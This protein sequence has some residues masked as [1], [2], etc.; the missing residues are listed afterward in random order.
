VTLRIDFNAW[1]YEREEHLLIPLLKT[2]ERTL[3]DYI[4]LL[5]STPP[6]PS[7]EA[8]AA[9]ASASAGKESRRAQWSERLSW[10]ADRAT[11][12]GQ[13]AIAMTKM[14]KVK[15]GIPG[16]GEVEVAPYE[17]L[18]AAQAQIDRAEKMKEAQEAKEEAR[19]AAAA[20]KARPFDEQSLYYNIYLELRRLTRGDGPDAPHLNFVFLIDDL[21]R[22]LPEKAVETLESIKL[23]LDVEGCVFVLAIDD[24]VVE[25]GIAHR[26]RDYL[27]VTDRAAESID[28]SLNADL[29][30]DYLNRYANN[31]QPPI[32]GS[33]YLEKI[34]Q[35]PIR[36]PRFSRQ[37][38]T[39]LLRRHSPELF[40]QSEPMPGAPTTDWLLDLFLEAVPPVP[41]KLIRAADLLTFVRQLAQRQGVL[42]HLHAYTLA[43]LVL[44]QLFAPQMFRY[45]TRRDRMESWTRLDARMQAARSERGVDPT[46]ASFFGWWE[47]AMAADREV[48][49]AGTTAGVTQT[50]LDRYEEP[51]VAELRQAVNTRSGF[52][53]RR[54]FHPSLTVD[55]RLRPYFNLLAEDAAVTSPP[56]SPPTPPPGGTV[57]PGPSPSLPPPVSVKPPAVPTAAPIV[58]PI[59]TTAPPP[60]PGMAPVESA[61]STIAA[62]PRE[63]ENFIDLLMSPHA[64]SWH[65]ALNSEPG[66]QGR[67]LDAQSFQ[68]LRDRINQRGFTISG[69]WLDVVGV[70][71]SDTQIKMLLVAASPAEVGTLARLASSSSPFDTFV[72]GA[73][74][75]VVCRRLQPWH[76]PI[77]QDLRAEVGL[78]R[79]VDIRRPEWAYRYRRGLI[80]DAVTGGEKLALWRG[81][82]RVMGAQV[83]S[84][85]EITRGVVAT[86]SWTGDVRLW[87]RAFRGDWMT[88]A[89]L[90][91]RGA[92]NVAPL[93]P[94]RLVVWGPTTL[95]IWRKETFDRWRRTHEY[96]VSQPIDALTVL[97]E[98]CFVHRS[99]TGSISIWLWD[100]EQWNRT[101]KPVSGTLGI[102]A[103]GPRRFATFGAGSS[104]IYDIENGKTGNSRSWPGDQNP[105][106]AVGLAPG[107]AVLLGTSGDLQLVRVGDE[108]ITVLAQETS[109]IPFGK[110]AFP[111]NDRFL[112]V[113]DTGAFE[114]WV[115]SLNSD[116][117]GLKK[118]GQGS[119]GTPPPGSFF[120]PEHLCVLRDGRVLSATP[121]AV[122]TMA[123]NAAGRYEVES[124]MAEVNLA[125]PAVAAWDSGILLGHRQGAVSIELGSNFAARIEAQI[126]A[127]RTA[128]RDAC[129][130]GNEEIALVDGGSTV[131][132]FNRTVNSVRALSL[133]IS[134]VRL[135]T[136]AGGRL[137]V[138]GAS[139]IVELERDGTEWTNRRT[140]FGVPADYHGLA[141]AD[142]GELIVWNNKQLCAFGDRDTSPMSPPG[143]GEWIGSVGPMSKEKGTSEFLVCSGGIVQVLSL[144]PVQLSVLL[145]PPDIASLAAAFA[146][147][148]LLVFSQSGDLYVYEDITLIRQHHHVLHGVPARLYRLNDHCALVY[149]LD[150]AWY[151]ID[152]SPDGKLRVLRFLV[153]DNAVVVQ[154]IAVDPDTGP[155]VDVVGSSLLPID[156]TLR[157][158]NLGAEWLVKGP[159]DKMFPTDDAVRQ[160]LAFLR[161]SGELAEPASRPETMTLSS[162]T[163]PR[164]SP[165]LLVRSP[166]PTTALLE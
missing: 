82:H 1:R 79:D 160:F 3:D 35:L 103:L 63:L 19:K 97:G 142:T 69:R 62:A 2:I 42:T 80:S 39:E 74:L 109:A 64:D 141:A 118:L 105:K 150:D 4:T 159:G 7:P 144:K 163:D 146:G 60:V 43:Q 32:T 45:L 143:E 157:S 155:D 113:D 123:P 25:R 9:T 102:I 128:F 59:T 130:I 89:H 68:T 107:I 15:A 100:G 44:L 165:A 27:D 53:P 151:R 75:E 46:G 149:A 147:K 40:V 117:P 20:K 11:L 48:A 22:C 66:L 55:P 152:V 26:Y 120:R 162:E 129:S 126:P 134:D 136:S 10:L 101:E 78:P 65:G 95:W 137:Y 38:A 86:C 6:E 110:M 158:M 135:V 161:V 71:L 84:V 72:L 21:D 88:H 18:T 36:L 50:Q 73:L 81:Y 133:D 124:V 12:V 76:A 58:P 85:R 132:L 49:K 96:P 83:S 127:E 108:G 24:E 114:V 148:L 28:H 61:P 54:L 92:G 47:K 138:G 93:S 94:F 5:K 34:V 125:V 87:S 70:V 23:F 140:L 30:R 106:E 116:T 90:A 115:A 16:F 98:D 156:P 164:R 131:Y 121:T 166:M 37:Q 104:W 17:A 99:G 29:Y 51:L 52:D 145:R 112:L 13:C 14:V 67:V 41:R 119:I 57:S 91:S 122:V 154:E 56:P 8:P 111:S 139:S 153:G 31:R 77:V 33:E